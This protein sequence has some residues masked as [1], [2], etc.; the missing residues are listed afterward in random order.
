MIVVERK[1]SELNA[2][3]YN[4]R[5]I[6]EKQFRDLKV[7]M[8]KFGFAVPVV[9]NVNPERKDVIIGGHQ[10]IRVW[11]SM[12]NKTVP[13]VELNLSLD[14]EREL[15]VRLNKNTGSFDFD[16]LAN[17]FDMEDLI[18]FGFEDWELGIGK[19]D[20]EKPAEKK[21]SKKKL[22][23]ESDDYKELL[24]IYELATDKGLKCKIS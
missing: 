5:Q 8:S 22:T 23:I 24:E 16:I 1:I 13:T 12:G 10:R 4:G 20:D 7:S 11:E 14:Q 17:H 21:E 18:E 15:N 6:T 3:E 19:I 2:A 9:V